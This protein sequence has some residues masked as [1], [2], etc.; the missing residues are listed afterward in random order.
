M[1]TLIFGAGL[2]GAPA[3]LGLPPLTAIAGPL[4]LL[5][6]LGQ[7]LGQECRPAPESERIA[8]AYAALAAL[9]GRF[10]SASFAVDPW[11]TA[12]RVLWLRD[13]LCLAGWDGTVDASMPP[14][15]ADLAA[16]PPLPVGQPDILHTLLNA[17]LAA[18]LPRLMLL[19]PLEVWPPLWRNLLTRLNA[20]PHV[21]PATQAK[22]DLGALQR[23]F[24][25]GEAATWQGDGS[26]TLLTGDGGADCADIISTMLPSL[27]FNTAL[28]GGDA[29]PLPLL[30]RA[31]HLPRAAALTGPTVGA[32]L[33]SLALA[34]HWEPFDAA[35]ALEFLQL[36]EH[37][38]GGATRFLIDAISAHPGHGGV[39]YRE[40]V[41]AARLAKLATDETCGIEP[42][43]REKRAQRRVQDIADWLPAMRF[44]PR[45]NLPAATILSV[46]RRIAN[47]AAAR[48]R[49][50]EA[51]PANAL[52]RA[53]A[54]SG[55]E[56]L[57]PVLLGRMLETVASGDVTL[58]APEAAP[59]RAFSS[60]TA[61]LDTASATFWWLG[62]AATQA[63][64]PWRLHEHAWMRG[65]G[66]EPDN[67]LAP[68]RA[69]L[70]LVRAIS[71]TSERLILVSPR[72]GEE[73][74]QP[75]PLLGL[76]AGCFGASLRGAWTEAQELQA[77]GMVAGVQ[78]F[79][80][81]LPPLMPP[82]PRRDWAVP[83]K[84]I[85]P[86]E[87][88]SP[89]GLEKLLGCPL[90]WVLS[91][92][93][94]LYARG[95]AAL[96]SPNQMVGTLLHEVMHQVFANGYASP[97]DAAA[98]AQA[99]F[100]RLAPEMAAPL[101]KPDYATFYGRA[102]TRISQAMAD[103]TAKLAS[104][105]LRLVGAEES[106]TRALP[107]QVGTLGGRLDLLF[108]GAK[109]KLVLDA[110][111]TSSAKHYAS[112]LSE[113]TALQLA[114]YA[115]L[116]GKGATAAY[117]LLRQQRLLAADIYPFPDAQVQGGDL[118]ACWQSA[119]IDFADA[120]KALKAGQVVAAGIE[121]PAEDE[122]GLAIEAPCRFCNYA[123]LCGIS[124]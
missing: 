66:L 2:D 82:A 49:P 52:E 44:S 104:A 101:L 27:P 3:P 97:T 62:P 6:L 36:P 78:L 15:V 72:G 77:G 26:L 63:A 13:D 74:A 54:R 107:G 40:A 98:K 121:P 42:Q 92:K 119:M 80:E 22:G 57:S 123:S 18:S 8:A 59:W 67:D 90:A 105:K 120:L 70:G 85:G 37:P 19:E 45:D 75:H 71:L 94:K 114:A 32:Q 30:L 7:W 33:L 117:Y 4:G 103:L 81:R 110:K 48:Q 5:D 43:E 56:R 118:A 24:V 112:R 16:L 96:P 38:L 87:M 60:P 39:Q 102:R 76:L 21:L 100:E 34:L 89:S 23:W 73:A 64:S 10:W 84:L 69:R 35:A 93:A 9:P 106:F 55:I 83:A 65:R 47:W 108:E 12:R 116:V 50:E 28:L 58:A 46:C 79:T 51:G 99:L 31:R 88:E 20:T 122:R 86:R 95:P 1:T 41:E 111:W 91:Y 115:W 124:A 25:T 68:K 109:G 17:P 113:N 11:A 14:R 29:S 61:R 53:I